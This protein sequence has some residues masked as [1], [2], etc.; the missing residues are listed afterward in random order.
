MSKVWF[1]GYN[2]CTYEG[3]V[4]HYIWGPYRSEGCAY[5]ALELHLRKPRTRFELQEAWQ[6]WGE[7]VISESASQPPA[8]HRLETVWKEEDDE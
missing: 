8:P 6:V 2:D 7:E 3:G 5:R 1:F 4:S